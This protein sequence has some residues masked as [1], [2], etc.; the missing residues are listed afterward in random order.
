M[1]YFIVW[2]VGAFFVPFAASGMTDEMEWHVF[3]G[4][5]Y[6]LIGL[7]W[8]LFLIAVFGYAVGRLIGTMIKFG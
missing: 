2:V 3:D 8:P 7:F 4:E 6:P 5:F 1:I